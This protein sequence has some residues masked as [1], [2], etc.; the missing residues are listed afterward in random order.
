MKRWQKHF[1]YFQFIS[2]EKRLHAPINEKRNRN[3]NHN[4]TSIKDSHAYI[5]SVV[6]HSNVRRDIDTRSKDS[7][8][9]IASHRNMRSLKQPRHHATEV[10]SCNQNKGLSVRGEQRCHHCEGS[11]KLSGVDQEQVLLELIQPGNIC[12]PPKVGTFRS[13]I[14]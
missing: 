5:R 7:V 9:Q 10:E 2:A 8:P 6:C 14:E 13:Q 3:H 11:C 4:T 12:Y 1:I